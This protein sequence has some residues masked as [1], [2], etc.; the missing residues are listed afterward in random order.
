MKGSKLESDMIDIFA[1][2]LWLEWVRRNRSGAEHHERRLFQGSRWVEKVAWTRALSERSWM[3][4][5]TCC[6]KTPG[7]PVGLDVGVRDEEGP[8]FGAWISRVAGG[9]LP[10][11]RKVASFH[12]SH[13]CCNP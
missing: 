12:N 4:L 13:L 9:A 2:S 1:A 8:K 10:W 7:L 5:R 3:D 11:D 6:R